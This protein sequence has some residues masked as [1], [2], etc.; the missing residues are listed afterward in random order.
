ML[1]SLGAVIDNQYIK[2]HDAPKTNNYKC[3]DC[4][5]S[6]ILKFGKIRA[7]HFSHKIKCNHKTTN[8]ILDFKNKIQ[9]EGF[10]CQRQCMNCNEL[11][12][13]SI[14]HQTIQDIEIHDT[15]ITINNKIILELGHKKHD[16]Y[17]WYKINKSFE[18]ENYMC[19]DCKYGQVYF[20]QRGAGCGKT[21]ESIQ[22]LNKFK[23]KKIIVYLTK[24]HSAKEVIYGELRSQYNDGHLYNISLVSETLDKKYKIVLKRLHEEFIILIGTIDSF[25]YSIYDKSDQL[26]ALDPFND[27]VNKIHEG[28]IIREINYGNTQ[29]KIDYET[30]IIIDEA[31]DLG[32]N[33]MEAFVTI[34]NKTKT[35][36]YIIGDKL[37]SIWDTKNIYTCIEDAD[38]TKIT[39]SDGINK[40]MRFH[41]EQFKYFVNSLVPYHKYNLPKVEQICDRPC[42]YEHE[43]IKP[44]TMFEVPSTFR[45]DIDD[46]YNVIRNIKTYMCQEIDKYNYVPNNFMFIF[47]ILKKNTFAHVL[48]LE[49]NN[50]WIEKYNKRDKYVF[51]HKSEPGQIIN[52]KESENGTRILS[53]HTSKGT[54][55]EVVFL[56]GVTEHALKIFSKQT[57]NI[58]YNSLLHVAVTRQKK[59]IYVGIENNNDDICRRFINI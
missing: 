15:T 55:C 17:E 2:P 5:N 49:L 27:I 33:Y 14:L 6:I 48:S 59:A 28:K 11:S 22:L 29:I 30:L 1:R 47:P 39:K 4:D 58:V 57:D 43:T 9:R 26:N 46:M 24:T 10:S 35:D 38:I 40:V 41:N 42:K 21:Y 34:V 44:Y 3:P 54:G 16:Q 13:L 8:H 23:N 12:W 7:P 56:L 52:L 45:T 19:H 18:I 50:F 36:L 25:T 51:L 32:K 53:I 20:N 31:Q 37:Q